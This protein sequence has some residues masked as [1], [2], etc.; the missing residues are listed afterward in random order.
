M[1][2]YIKQVKQGL[3]ALMAAVLILGNGSFT[4]QPVYANE[5]ADEFTY[6]ASIGGATM[7]I[8]KTGELWVWGWNSGENY[9]GRLGD[10]TT[11]D[12]YSPVKIMDNVTSVVTDHV[13]NYALAL[14]TDGSLWSWGH[15][16]NGQLGDGTTADRYS[17]AKIME[18]VAAVA[19][20]RHGRAFAI[21]TDGSLWAWGDN[22]YGSLGVGVA[23]N[24]HS[25]VMIMENVACVE[26][27]ISNTYAIQTDGSLWAWGFNGGGQLGDGTVTHRYSPVKIMEKVA[28][29]V[30]GNF[31]N[32][33]IQTDGSLWTWGPNVFGTVGDGTTEVRRTPIKILENVVSVSGGDG[34]IYAIIEDGS[35]WGWGKNDGG[36]LGD[37][38]NINRY[39]PVKIMENVA[40]VESDNSILNIPHTF[41]VKTDGSL[42]G[43]GN[44]RNAR[45][46]EDRRHIQDNVSNSTPVRLMEDVASIAA[47]D[48]GSAFAIKTDGSLWAWGSN[49][50]GK[51]GVGDGMGDVYT[52]IKIMENVMDVYLDDGHSITYA[53]RADGSLWAWGLNMHGRIGDGTTDN[54][55]IPVRITLK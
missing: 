24:R 36:Q 28:S 33:A 51:L 5:Q 31:F 48:D 46:G 13:W 19:T 29:L 21:K 4:A 53:I 12:R 40:Y 27:K 34:Y 10:G 17:P 47:S 7:A 55:S 37:G 3:A 42:W 14:Q 38:T 41:V 16:Y 18:D 9:A 20:Q 39:S 11:E 44:S 8:T 54:R 6:V 1:R 26:A 35:L 50:V 15:N 52:P 32:A 2:K 49:V 30:P 22:Y 43:W 25:P 45:V 23:G